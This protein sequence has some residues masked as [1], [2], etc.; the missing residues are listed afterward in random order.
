MARRIRYTVRHLTNEGIA[1]RL[2]EFEQRYGMTSAEFLQ[3]YHR[4]ELGDDPAF[5]DWSGLLYVA[6]K[7][8]V[9]AHAST[10][11]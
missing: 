7:V 1:R 4:G 3:R 11:R 8:G 6:N 5:I 9:S 2:V 10:L